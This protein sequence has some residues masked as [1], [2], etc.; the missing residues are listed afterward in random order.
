MT[1]TLRARAVLVMPC[2]TCGVDVGQSCRNLPPDR[3]HYD[4]ES[5]W[6][7]YALCEVCERYP[8]ETRRGVWAVACQGHDHVHTLCGPCLDPFTVPLVALVYCPE[9]PEGRAAFRCDPVG[10]FVPLATGA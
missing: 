7:N 5:D 4:R 1:P 2:D 3:T 9:T 8:V 10:R 6:C